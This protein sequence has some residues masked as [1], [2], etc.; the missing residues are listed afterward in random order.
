MKIDID[1]IGY[2]WKGV[3]SPNIAYKE[4]DVVFKDGGAHVIRNGTPQAFALGQQDAI[5]KGH[6][7]TG[8]VSVGGVGAMVL[9]ANSNDSIEFRFMGDRNGTTVARLMDT[10]QNHRVPYASNRFGMFVMTD[11]SVR[12]IGRSNNGQMGDGGNSDTS[13]YNAGEAAFPKGV[14][15]SRVIVAWTNTYYIDTNGGLWFSG[16]N[17][18]SWMSGRGLSGVIRTPVLLNGNSGIPANAKIVEVMSSYGYYGYGE[19]LALDSQGRVYAWGYNQSGC[20]GVNN[21]AGTAT[22]TLIPFTATV[23]IK[24]IMVNGNYYGA[25][26]LIDYAGNAWVCGDNSLAWHTAAGSV[27]VHQRLDLGGRAVKKMFWDENDQHWVAGSQYDW[28]SG[29]LFENGEVYLRGTGAG[30]TGMDGNGWT[31][32]GNNSAFTMPFHTGVKDIWVQGGGY[33]T[34]IALMNDGTIQ[35]KGYGGYGINGNIAGA[36]ANTTTWATIGGSFLTNITKLEMMGGQYGSTAAALRSDGQLVVWGGNMQGVKGDGSAWSADNT[37]P[38]SFFIH[39]RPIVDFCFGG[40]RYEATGVNCIYALDDQGRVVCSGAGDY[41][42]NGDDD[43]ENT[44]TPQFI[45]F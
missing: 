3:Y 20:L 5:L 33:Q 8:G 22:A 11:G 21:G 1:S 12:C 36:A 29:I 16:N 2:R 31:M 38:N 18:G 6:L 40:M 32:G 37:F 24:S 4:R 23:P 7:L 44:A 14:L 45:R 28:T 30:Q 10:V 27:S 43:A 41:S 26:C 25:S 35:A 15:I 17:D 13:R 19:T 34:A 39:D 42:M 9:H